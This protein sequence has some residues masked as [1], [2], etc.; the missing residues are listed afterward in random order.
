MRALYAI[1]TYYLLTKPGI[2]MGNSITML[3]GFAL[4][5]RGAFD[6]LLFLFTLLGLSLVIG[7]ACA[8]NNYIDKVADQKMKRTE[9][10][11]LARGLIS[12]KS[13]CIFAAF[14]GVLGIAIL[15]FL[16]NLL[17]A[18][19]A[20]VGFFTYVAI[21][22]F[23]KYRSV[24]ATLIGSISGAM[25]PVVGYVATSAT[26]DMGSFILFAMLVTWQMPHFFAIAIYRMQDY[27]AA[28]IPVLPV[29]KGIVQTKW[30]MALY[31]AAFVLVGQLLFYFGYVSF[32]YSLIAAFLGGLWLILCFLGFKA[33]NDTLWA[34]QMFI[35]SLVVMIGV[36]LTLPFFI[37]T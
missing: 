19:M 3:S 24:H 27:S 36:F 20:W 16:V 7:S 13:A 35:V 14:L 18:L 37:S 23:L 15:A 9:H 21:Y 32:F 17:A 6:P 30:Q 12:G 25:P 4:G 33:H 26:L 2:I 28:L 29:K 11:P 22:S 10:R 31:T 1:R 5:S 8:F 34:R